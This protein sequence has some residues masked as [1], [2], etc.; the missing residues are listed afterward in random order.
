MLVLKAEGWKTVAP[1][2]FKM[3]AANPNPCAE[4]KLIISEV[5]PV[6]GGSSATVTWKTNFPATSQVRIT[7]VSTGEVIM[8]Q[9]DSNL[10]NEHSVQ[11]EGLTR[12]EAFLVEVISVDAKGNQVVG[13]PPVEI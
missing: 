10:V 8:S 5:A 7:S 11:I 3:P 1:A 2:N 12:G 13:H 4:D 6:R 9:L